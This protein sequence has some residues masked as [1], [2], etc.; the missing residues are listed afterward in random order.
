MATLVLAAGAQLDWEEDYRVPISNNN[1]TKTNDIGQA[2]KG[3]IERE[4]ELYMLCIRELST[5]FVLLLGQ[6]NLNA[7]R[8]VGNTLCGL[9][10]CG[11]A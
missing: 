5:S 7:R 11:H 8:E 2:M 10:S 9:M 3:E 4:R 1:E 6:L